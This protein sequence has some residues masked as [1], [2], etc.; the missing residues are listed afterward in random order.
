MAAVMRW[1]VVRTI[2]GVVA[3]CI[4]LVVVVWVWAEWYVCSGAR[5][6]FLTKFCS[7]VSKFSF[8]VVSSSLGS[9][10]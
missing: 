7:M 3:S 10:S 2:I 4:L 6:A 1:A 8:L 9:W 5:I